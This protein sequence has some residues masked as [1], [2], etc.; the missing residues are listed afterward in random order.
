MLK[1]CSASETEKE[2]RRWFTDEHLDLIVWTE[3]GG[4]S[5]AGF[6]LC[7]DKGRQERAL[8]WIKNRGYAHERVDDGEDTPSKNSTPILLPD[9]ACPIGELADI[10][11]RKS[12]AIDPSIRSFIM[13]KLAEYHPA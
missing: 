10:F 6:Q 2:S 3:P 4:G 5:I 1:E 9:G 12:T 7:Y 8:T 11:S 13:Q